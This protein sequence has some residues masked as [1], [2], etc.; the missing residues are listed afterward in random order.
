MPTKTDIADRI[1][2]LVNKVAE[3]NNVRFAEL[4]GTS[5]ANIRNYIAGVK[6]KYDFLRTVADKLEINAEWLLRGEGEIFKTKSTKNVLKQNEDIFEDIFEDKRKVQKT[7]SKDEVK[8]ITLDSSKNEVIPIVDI[9]AAAGSGAYNPD[10]IETLDV[11]KMPPQLLKKGTHYCI[12]VSGDSMAP[13]L[14]DGGYV[15]SRVLDRSE[16]VY[17]KTGYVYVVS[18]TE[19]LAYVKRIKNRLSERGE[20]VLMSDN[21]DKTHFYDLTLGEDEIHTVCEVEW[22]LSTKLSDINETYYGRLREMA[23]DIDDL[24]SAMRKLLK[25]PY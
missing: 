2:R 15:I 13:T 6:P 22:Y 19:G 8:I 20:I 14:Q 23:D 11:I 24:K 17:I 3:G 12:G 16:W 4:V 21:P 5:E 7:S 10:F 25:N 18:T 9:A 1:E